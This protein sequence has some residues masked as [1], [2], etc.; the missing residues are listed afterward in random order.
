MD[1][2]QHDILDHGFVIE[3]VEMLEH[4]SH[5][6]AVDIDV[7]AHIRNIYAIKKDLPSGGIFH[8]V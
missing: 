2:C 8:T 4:H 3:Q 6:L 5:L 1:R 7:H